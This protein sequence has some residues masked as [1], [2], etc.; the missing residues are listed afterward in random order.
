M[1]INFLLN[2]EICDFSTFN[3]LMLIDSE[4]SNYNIFYDNCKITTFPI[5][6]YKK[7][8]D[9][10]TKDKFTRVDNNKLQ[11]KFID[12]TSH[13]EDNISTVTQ[14]EELL[15]FVKNHNFI[16][17]KRVCVVANNSFIDS[18][19]PFLDY[20][21]FLTVKILLLPITQTI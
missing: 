20:E 19:K 15:N 16:N 12:L 7:T 10:F 4:V 13:D 11:K 6:Y 8:K 1:S 17:L 5:I 18:N 21:S 2:N 9:I 14:K 3:N